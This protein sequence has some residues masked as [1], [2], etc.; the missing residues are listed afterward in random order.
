MQ[1][2]SLSALIAFLLIAMTCLPSASVNGQQ[3]NNQ[4]TE[5][6][7]TNQ[8]LQGNWEGTIEL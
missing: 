1:N 6:R 4:M 2:Q 7:R 5:S 8:E 3:Q